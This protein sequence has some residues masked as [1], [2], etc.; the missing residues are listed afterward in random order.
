MLILLK[1]KRVKK[2]EH[3]AHYLSSSIKSDLNFYWHY[4]PSRVVCEPCSD[5]ESNDNEEYLLTTMVPK[6]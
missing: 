4:A 2:C 5:A 6:Q 1:M 3:F